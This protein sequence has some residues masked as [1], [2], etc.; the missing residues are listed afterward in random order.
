MSECGFV[1]PNGMCGAPGTGKGGPCDRHRCPSCGKG[2][3]SAVAFCDK[4]RAMQRGEVQSRSEERA[5]SVETRMAASI[6][7]VKANTVLNADEKAR[8]AP[9][10]IELQLMLEELRDVC[11]V[12]FVAKKR[13]R[14]RNSAAETASGWGTHRISC[15]QLV[16][17]VADTDSVVL[18]GWEGPLGTTPDGRSMKASLAATH[19]PAE[20][21]LAILF[22]AVE[23][24]W[25]VIAARHIAN[26]VGGGGG[27]GSG[28][29]AD[30]AGP[31]EN[32]VGGAGYPL[33]QHVPPDLY[34]ANDAVTGKYA[35][36][37]RNMFT[38]S[39]LKVF[40]DCSDNLESGALG[41][42][43]HNSELDILRTHIKDI[44]AGSDGAKLSD[45]LRA[46]ACNNAAALK[47]RLTTAVAGIAGATVASISIKSNQ[48]AAQKVQ[49][50]KH[51]AGCTA[52]FLKYILDF[53]RIS[54]SGETIADMHQIY[55]AVKAE[56]GEPVSCKE[57]LG[58]PTHD[59]MCIAK[60]AGADGGS[61]SGSGMLAEIQIHHA[62]VLALK[63]FM[64]I[65][66]EVVHA[67]LK[68]PPAPDGLVHHGV[69]H[70][71]EMTSADLTLKTTYIPSASDASVCGMPHRMSDPGL[72]TG[73]LDIDGGAVQ[74]IEEDEV[75]E[76]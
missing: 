21:V 25:K 16:Q 2:K 5:R 8:L 24:Q 34:V 7:K 51:K 36:T 66:Y 26:T 37:R 68:V 48:R 75:D 27:G 57:R 42:L 13:F 72:S 55:L 50:Y 6:A 28:E 45:Y 38:P 76:V 61:G 44:L 30:I 22:E 32:K 17:W 4:C 18:R 59:V 15:G 49:E 46:L 19:P 12:I 53:L 65:P 31:V 62:D 23:R 29:A 14:K 60:L 41:V 56:F 74:H 54:V 40:A 47:V 52:P 69:W 58:K 33:H 71:E 64:H 35:T 67:D 3:T 20:E 63:S 43:G 10:M 11:V 39:T 73:V 1:S 9:G 70:A